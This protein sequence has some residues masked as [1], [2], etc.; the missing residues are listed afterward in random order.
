M[1]NSVDDTPTVQESYFRKQR[2]ALYF[3]IFVR[4]RHV[5]QLYIC[6]HGLL[7]WV[8]LCFDCFSQLK[9][10]NRLANLR[11][12]CP[13]LTNVLCAFSRRV[14]LLSKNIHSTALRPALLFFV[15]C[16]S[17]DFR[18]TILQKNRRI[19]TYVIFLSNSEKVS[20]R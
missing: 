4:Q 14:F 10:C 13:V 16:C 11:D 7:F 1:N 17:P 20:S 5:Q 6:F 12:T 8:I 19:F 18:R 2:K 15:C 3:N 9:L